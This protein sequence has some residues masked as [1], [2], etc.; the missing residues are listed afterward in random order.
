MKKKIHVLIIPSWYPRFKGDI[1]GSFFRE[2]A[3]ALS[4]RNCQVGVIYPQFRSLKNWKGVFFEPYGL[5]EE[6]DEQL[7]TLRWHSVVFTPKLDSFNKKKWINAGMKL[8]EQYIK[9]KGIPDII[10]VHSM[11]HGG[12]L[13][14]Q[15]LKKY[16]I[17]YVITEHNSMF[18]RDLVVKKKIDTLTEIVN[19]ASNC[20]SVSNSFKDKLNSVFNTT[21]WEYLPN[22]VNDN[23]FENSL[24]KENKT[25]L[26][27]Y[28]SVCLLTKN[29]KIDLLIRAFS[30]ILEVFPNSVLYIVGDGP[31]KK[32]LLELTKKLNLTQNIIFLG[33]LPREKVIEIMSEVDTLIIASEFETFGV[34]A[35]EALALGKPVVSTKCG[36]PQSIINSEEVGYLVENNSLIGLKDGLI[37]IQQN[38][39]KFSSD[40]I[41]NY[42][43]NN[44]GEAA[45]V[46]QLKKIYRE[47]LEQK[48]NNG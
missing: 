3:I 40:K 16:K 39:N 1:S 43:L 31:E 8:F 35:V 9:I 12:E 2:Q 48:S 32:N 29:K 18:L 46:E 6:I 20:I 24:T 36:G 4:K 47:A 30:L 11:L 23:F 28:C 25:N 37:N 45:V 7:F 27:K 38:Y 26:F 22:I 5:S 42:C 44:F 19:N 17:P 33:L 10:H 41:R 14:D 21:K 13:A 15:I 34:V